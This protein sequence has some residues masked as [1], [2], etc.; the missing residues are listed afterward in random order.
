MD[1]FWSNGV[2]TEKAACWICIEAESDPTLE[3]IQTSR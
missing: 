2:L 1:Y 3:K